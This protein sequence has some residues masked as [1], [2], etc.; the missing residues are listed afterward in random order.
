MFNAQ[1]AMAEWLRS[2]TYGL[3]PIFSSSLNTSSPPL[4]SPSLS[5]LLRPLLLQRLHI[6]I[7]RIP[8]L[9]RR[10]A[11]PPRVLD[12]RLLRPRRLAA[13]EPVVGREEGEDGADCYSDLLSVAG[14]IC[15]GRE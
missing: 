9:L 12:R 2:P 5:L 1:V 3:F 8:I 10:V 13:V 6:A 7:P 15:A 4:H 11:V 14:G